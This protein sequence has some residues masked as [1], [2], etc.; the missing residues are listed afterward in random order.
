MNY[1]SLEM[2]DTE[3]RKMHLLGYKIQYKT[4][5]LLSYFAD[6]TKQGKLDK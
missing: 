3:Y 2:L 4:I 6:K 1:I 5:Q